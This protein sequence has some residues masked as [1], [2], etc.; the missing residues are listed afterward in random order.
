MSLTGRY[1]SCQEIIGEVY[2]DNKYKV[3][4]PW[5]DAIAWSVDAVE[6]IGAPMAYQPRQALIKIENY[7]GMIPCY[8]HSI[9]QV[10]G[11]FDG[12]IPFAMTTDT[13]SF[14]SVM[15]CSD[16]T[17]NPNLI[18]L[19]NITTNT[20]TQPI[21][22]D[23]SGNPMY[24]FN[25]GVMSLPETI[26]DNSN[27]ANN[28]AKYT[29]S[30]SY[31]FTNYP[32]GYVFIACKAFPIDNEGFPLIPDNRRFKEA[33][34]SF[35]RFKID[36][37]LWRTGEIDERMF[38]YSETEWLFY[39]PSASNAAKMPSKDNLQALMNQIKLIPRRYAHTNLFQ[40]LGV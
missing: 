13:N 4:L 33:V 22:Q 16:T 24:K 36:Y 6:L 25:N 34:K 18:D 29:L 23:I 39:C 27:R 35:I 38:K 37:I 14:H 28:F 1:I 5:Q 11:S 15:N 32:D 12:C 2:R 40:T 31:I 26:T 19:A 30:D 8:V 7:R 17:I 3:E 9:E 20:N 21:G 10:A